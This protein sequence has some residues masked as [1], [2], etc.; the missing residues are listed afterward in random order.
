MSAR[1]GVLV[2]LG[3]GVLVAY[4]AS[5]NT[6]R[7]RVALSNDRGWEVPLASLV[8]GAF[9]AG[10]VVTLLCVLVRDVGRS[11]RRRRDDRASRRAAL[12]AREAGAASGTRLEAVEG[13]KEMDTVHEGRCAPERLTPQEI[14][15]TRSQSGAG[16]SPGDN[17]RA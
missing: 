1:L 9:L 2:A 3:F 5:Q 14:P 13:Q 11:V 10:V 7:V 15:T 4:L 12:E 17:P 16:V 8:V 6:S